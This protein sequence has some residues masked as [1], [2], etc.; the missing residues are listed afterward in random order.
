MLDGFEFSAL[1]ACPRV[2]KYFDAVIIRSPL[3][4]TFMGAE[5][6]SFFG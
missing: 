1:E 5:R 6:A 3:Q 2:A 4:G